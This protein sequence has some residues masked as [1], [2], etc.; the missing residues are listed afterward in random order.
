MAKV[1]MPLADGV[2]EIE[3][4]VAVDM[5]R[6][7]GWVVTVAGL[8]AGPITAS[9][10]VRMIP[11]TLLDDRISEQD[12]DVLLISGGSTGVANLRSD[13]RVIALVKAFAAADKWIGA[14]CAGPL[15]LQAAGILKG[16]HATCH[17]GVAEKLTDP[18]RGV[19]PV[20]VD[21]RL[22]TS[23][24]AGTMF[25]YILTLI[26]LVSGAAIARDVARGMVLDPDQIAL[27]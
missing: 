15:V 23:Q 24:G 11:D 14:V 12:F 21:G 6:R 17:P 9:R 19:G 8:T 3:A 27:Q 20:V 2:E 5:L 18:L 4:V 7:A 13:A 25:L 16:R 1:L 10:G 22:V 26:R